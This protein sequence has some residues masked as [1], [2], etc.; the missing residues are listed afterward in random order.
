MHSSEPSP[1][2]SVVIELSP[3]YT[4]Q[5][6]PVRYQSLWLLLRIIYAQQIEKRPLSAATIRAFFPQAQSIRMIISRA[7][8]EFSCL[9]IAVGW[10]HDQQIDLALLKLS[11]RSRGP[12]WLKADAL[13]Y[14]V[15]TRQGERLSADELGP[16]L[17]L[18]ATALPQMGM[19]GERSG[20]DYV[21]QDMRFWQHLTQGMRE[22]HDGFVRPAALRQSDPFL[23]AQQ[24]AQDDFQQALALMKAS[25]AWRRSDLLAESKQALSRFE[26]IIALG[27]LASARPTF[28]AMAQIVHAWDRYTL[29]D[30]EAARV[31]LMQLESSATLGPVVRYNP[32]VRFEFLN[33]SALLYKFD[34]MAEGGA[35]RQESADAA[36]QALSY[37]LEAA[38]EADSID[39][40]QHVA[41]NIGWCLWLFRQLDLLDQPLP[42]VQAQAMRWLGLSE[43][44]CDRFGVGSASAWNTIFILRIA[45]GNCHEASSLAAFRAQ[46]PMTLSEAALALQPLSAP[47]A[48]G[49]NHWFAWAQFTLEEYD[50]GQLRFPPL[51]LANLLLEAAWFCVFEQ[52]ASLTAYQIVERLRAQLLELRPSERVFFRDALSAIPLP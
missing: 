9:G 23:L 8:A 25:L 34:A 52:G 10:G 5:G 6:G 11:Q 29:G 46:Q 40:V 47:F 1:Q 43:W 31:L 18:H 17:G 42:A 20:V 19:A 36:L 27:Q 4:V 7:F 33:L 51:Q 28:A 35:L 22:G 12:F 16:F 26:H 37:A 2:P 49:F 39:A 50:S 44:I 32:R 14:F 15:F 45:R 38:C 30:T 13:E 41:A 21:M 24:C 48:L 3:P